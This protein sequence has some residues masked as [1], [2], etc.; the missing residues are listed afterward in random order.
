MRGDRAGFKL[1][2]TG[3]AAPDIARRVL[4]ME[5]SL[6]IEVGGDGTGADIGTLAGMSAPYVHRWAAAAK[7][8]S[9]ILSIATALHLPSA[10]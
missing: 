6:S 2:V 4:Q 3:L 9:L 5:P 10:L 7:L 1:Y 8:A